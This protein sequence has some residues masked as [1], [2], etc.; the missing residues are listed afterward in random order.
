VG[1]DDD[2][3]V[4]V[5]HDLG[6]AGAVGEPEGV[7][8]FADRPGDQLLT[9]RVQG[10]RRHHVADL[11]EAVRG[12]LLGDADDRVPPARG[13]GLDAELPALCELFAQGGGRTAVRRERVDVLHQGDGGTADPVDRLGDDPPVGGEQPVHRLGVVPRRERRVQMRCLALQH[14]PHGQ[15]V[16]G[17][18]DDGRVHAGDAEPAGGQ[19]GRLQAELGERDDGGGPQRA[20]HLVG[21]GQESRQVPE[22]GRQDPGARVEGRGAGQLYVDQLAGQRRRRPCHGRVGADDHESGVVVRV[23]RT[24]LVRPART[25]CVHF[26]LPLPH[27]LLVRSTRSARQCKR[28]QR[29]STGSRTV[30]IEPSDHA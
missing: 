7:E 18:A 13:E 9:A 21:E 10:G 4:A 14:A 6:V 3:L 19:R 28:A 11:D 22:V 27:R 8:E 12:A 29:M 30:T 26:F 20:Q 1:L 23:P 25:H 17:D 2:D 24:V 15:L 5:D 16:A